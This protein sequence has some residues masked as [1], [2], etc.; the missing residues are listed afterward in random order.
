V[1]WLPLKQFEWHTKVVEREKAQLLN[2]SDKDPGRQLTIVIDKSLTSP[3]LGDLVV[4]FHLLEF[5][6]RAGFD[7]RVELNNFSS[8]EI[9][10]LTDAFKLLFPK[11]FATKQNI[12]FVGISSGAG[13]RLFEEEMK[14]GLDTS[15]YAIPLIAALYPHWL[16]R[17]MVELGSHRRFGLRE[18]HTGPALIGIGVRHSRADQFRNPPD[19]VTLRDLKALSS[20]F[21]GSTIRWFGERDHYL[22]FQAAHRVDLARHSVLLEFQKSK[23]YFEALS[24]AKLMDFWFQRWGGGISV[25]PLFSSIPYLIISN[26]VAGSKISGFTG[27][28]QLPWRLPSQVIDVRTMTSDWPVRPK[29]LR[30]IY[31]RKNHER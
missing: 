4:N 22:Q 9:T 10:R 2:L 31:S 16:G 20:A 29:V 11:V 18:Q 23:E 25:S 27:R 3:G 15:R 6:R 19:I 8:R 30:R 24:E 7:A 13:V 12:L 21:P 17:G 1:K 5:L 26:D 14:L 28:G